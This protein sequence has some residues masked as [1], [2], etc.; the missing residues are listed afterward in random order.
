MGARD[1]DRVGEGEDGWEMLPLTP[2]AASTPANVTDFKVNDAA[3]GM[4][5]L[6]TT[7]CPLNQAQ[8]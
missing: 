4:G 1:R 3:A 5:K 7:T 8:L 6:S 2:N